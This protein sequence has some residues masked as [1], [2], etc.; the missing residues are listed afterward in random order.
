MD[1]FG[2]CTAGT[3][4]INTRDRK[5]KLTKTLVSIGYASFEGAKSLKEIRLL[6]KV[7]SIHDEAFF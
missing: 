1:E 6:D 4:R 5:V 7:K 3:A 2:K